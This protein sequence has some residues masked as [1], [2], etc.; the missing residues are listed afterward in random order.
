V[1]FLKI[2]ENS[3]NLEISAEVKIVNNYRPLVDMLRILDKICLYKKFVFKHSCQPA[4]N[5]LNDNG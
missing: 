4:A 5:S 2:K 1:N 3:R